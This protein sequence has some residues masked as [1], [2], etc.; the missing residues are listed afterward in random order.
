M[1]MGSA[2]VMLRGSQAYSSSSDVSAPGGP[3]ADAPSAHAIA[4]SGGAAGGPAAGD[5][6]ADDAA[7]VQ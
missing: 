2:S 1:S 6:A 5:A 7:P 3:D 4:D